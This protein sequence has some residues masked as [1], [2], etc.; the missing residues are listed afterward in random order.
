MVKEGK[1]D[2]AWDLQYESHSTKGIAKGTDMEND[3]E[4]VGMLT[5][6]EFPGFLPSFFGIQINFHS[7]NGYW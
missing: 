2:F 1:G 6:L 3:I 7:V 4:N 5:W